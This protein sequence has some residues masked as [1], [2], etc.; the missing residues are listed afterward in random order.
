ML[1]VLLA[2]GSTTRSFVL[3]DD[4]ESK[5]VACARARSRLRPKR[6]HHTKLSRRT[7]TRKRWSHDQRFY[8]RRLRI[9]ILCAS[10]A[11]KVWQRPVMI[12]DIE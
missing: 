12:D 3:D 1:S 7:E 11:P 2:G 10:R 9:Q 6:P 8:F 4:G 5:R